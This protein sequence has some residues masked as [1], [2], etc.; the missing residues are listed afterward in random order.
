MPGDIIISKLDAAGLDQVGR[1]RMSDSAD[2]ALQIFIRRFARRSAQASLTRTYVARDAGSPVVVGY[3]TMMCAEVAL[4]EGYK[5]SEKPG[6]ERWKYHPA[7]RIARLA[8]ADTHRR[9][10]LGR[11]LVDIAI[12]I[13][14]EG[15]APNVGCRFVIVDAKRKSINFYEKM[16]F[17]LLDTEVNRADAAPLMFL[18][19]KV[20]AAAL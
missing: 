9:T 3:V 7:V 12:G 11:K 18:D 15:I 13:I 2:E 10:G 19:L 5:I 14:A 8:V 4:A 1:F 17:R 20:I 6:A 16:G